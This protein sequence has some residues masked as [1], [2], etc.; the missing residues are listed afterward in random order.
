MIKF[1]LPPPVKIFAHTKIFSLPLKFSPAFWGRRRHQRRGAFVALRR[2]RNL[3]YGVFFLIAFSF[4][5]ASAK[6]KA[7][8]RFDFLF[9][10]L[11]TLGFYLVG[12]G[13]ID[14][15]LW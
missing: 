2:A 8:E 14:D 6:E 5:P 12:V 13:A 1:F 4:A 10:L 9:W 15:P 11:T 3:F 7:D